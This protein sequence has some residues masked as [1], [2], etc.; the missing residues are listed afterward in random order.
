MA[1]PTGTKPFRPNTR[2]IYEEYHKIKVSKEYDI[3]H[4]L[5]IRL[6]GTHD[7]ANLVPLTR[8][9]H[10]QAHFELY[11]K[12]KDPRDL[13]A[14]YMILGRNREA[15]LIACSLGGKA[16]QAIKK[17]RGDLNGF[18]LFDKSKLKKVTSKAGAI[19]GTKQKELGLGIHTDSDT[20]RKWA[21]LGG[22]ASIEK[23]GFKDS[24]RQSARGKIGGLKNKGSKW[25]NDGKKLFKYTA[26]Q[27]L[28]ES[29]DDFIIRTGLNKGR[30]K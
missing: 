23:N 2:K 16:S 9:D 1:K 29:F 10:A 13:C 8:Q 25:Y 5:P 22:L 21:K 4:V 28:K 27:Q 18:Q 20:R 7:V 12:H 17:R 24:S 14:Y 26:D 19:G 6:G 15:H 11:Q 3:H 30:L